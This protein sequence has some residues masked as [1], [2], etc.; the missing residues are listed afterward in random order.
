M[1]IVVLIDCFHHGDG[2]MSFEVLQLCQYRCL[3][4]VLRVLSSTG[5]RSHDSSY[6]AGYGVTLRCSCTVVYVPYLGCC[7]VLG[8]RQYLGGYGNTLRRACTVVYVPYLWYCQVLGIRQYLRGYGTTLPCACTVV[9][10]LYSCC[11]QVLG[12]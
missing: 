8:V 10:V 11:Y 9:Y 1:L 4:T 7:Q 5:T 6:L 2:Q 12:V 3:R